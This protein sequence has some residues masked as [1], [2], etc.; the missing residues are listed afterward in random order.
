MVFV[1]KKSKKSRTIIIIVVPSVASVELIITIVV[2]SRVKILIKKWDKSNSQIIWDKG[3][4]IVLYIVAI[5]LRKCLGTCSNSV[6]LGM[7]FLY[8]NNNNCWG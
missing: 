1:V 6:T 7:P 8:N 4:V 2:Y 5:I 3:E